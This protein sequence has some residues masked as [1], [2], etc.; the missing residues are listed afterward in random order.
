[1][2][3]FADELRLFR[4]RT[5]PKHFQG[6]IIVGTGQ[7]ITAALLI[8]TLKVD[9]IA[10]L[11]SDATKTMPDQVAEMLGC[12]SADWL[13]IPLSNTSTLAIYE[14]VKIV[15][16]QWKHLERSRIALDMTGGL[17]PMTVGLAKAGHL[18]GLQ[19]LYIESEY[20]KPPEEKPGPKPGTQRLII[21]PN[22]YKVFGDLEAEEAKHLYR[23][24]DYNGARRIFAKL[25]EQEQIPHQQTYQAYHHLSA[26]YAAWE[27][28]DFRTA[29]SELLLCTRL[30][31]GQAELLPYISTLK[32]Q[33]EDLQ[34]LLEI[35]SYV[36]GKDANQKLATLADTR[37]ILRLLGTLRSAAQRRAYN[38]RYDIAALFQYRAIEL[39]GQHRL[40]THKLLSDK[41]NYTKLQALTPDEL[42]ARFKTVQ[43]R[44]NQRRNNINEQPSG[45]L[46]HQHIT[47]FKA[48][49]LLAALDDA[50]IADYDWLAI[51]S[52][53][54]SR[55]ESILAHGYRLIDPS[56]Y[57]SFAQVA[58]ELYT[59]LLDLY[60]EDKAAWQARSQFIQPFA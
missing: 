10:F 57:K 23:N 46:P 22:P 58:D 1:M 48:Y 38:Q 28:L 14:G 19:T 16:E 24:H 32:Q 15:I 2:Y 30:A 60:G 37:A 5:E 44:V 59:R 25:A 40:A 54:A 8:G 6:L 9:H 45:K 50:L 31:S 21:P 26:A 4:D 52:R 34:A 18:L 47:L 27:V 51:E 17:K 3:T 7:S 13:R 11:L 49:M 43:L 53:T 20:G 42:K 12:S 39:I 35:T 56:E 29:E 33:C 36:A 55:N 41:P